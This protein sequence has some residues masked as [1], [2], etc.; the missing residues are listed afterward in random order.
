MS[1]T[2]LYLTSSVPNFEVISLKS[3]P[4]GS[5]SN[6]LF[7]F[8]SSSLKDI[9]VVS[10]TIPLLILINPLVTVE[11]LCHHL[12]ELGRLF[13]VHQVTST[14]DKLEMSVREVLP[15]SAKVL[16]LDIIGFSSADKQCVPM[17]LGVFQVLLGEV[18]DIMQV[19]L[20]RVQVDSPI[21]V[22]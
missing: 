18:K 14:F 6:G 20:Q 10:K 1:N 11:E 7:L 8:H 22:I 13:H 16:F 2:S 9:I 4:Q 21:K 17:E 15:Y 3:I 5:H 12:D 19:P